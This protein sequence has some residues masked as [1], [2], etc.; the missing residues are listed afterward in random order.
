MGEEVATDTKA[1]HFQQ[2]R[3]CRKFQFCPFK[4]PPPKWGISSPKFCTFFGR[5]F[6][7]G[8]ICG[9]WV[10][11]W[12][13]RRG[14]FAPPTFVFT[15]CENTHWMWCNDWQ[16]SQKIKSKII[17]HCTWTRTDWWASSQRVWIS[18]SNVISPYHDITLQCSLTTVLPTQWNT[19]QNRIRADRLRNTQELHNYCHTNCTLHGVTGNTSK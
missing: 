7:Q 8:K 13:V 16:H 4:P 17:F 11:S 3:K 2:Q 15:L 9:T 10:S 14:T 5:I 12:H 1:A 6:Q 18:T 19:Q